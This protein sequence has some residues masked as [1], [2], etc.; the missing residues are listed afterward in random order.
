MSIFSVFLIFIVGFQFFYMNFRNFYKWIIIES[1]I[2]KLLCDIGIGINL[3]FIGLRPYEILYYLM[4]VCSVFILY[5][6]KLTKLQKK[7]LLIFLFLIFLNNLLL[8]FFPL[9]YKTV[10]LPG[11]WY[12]Y[13]INGVSS[14]PSFGKYVLIYDLY[15]VIFYINVC[16]MKNFF[17][18]QE[19]II[20]FKKI[21][22]VSFILLLSIIAIEL[23]IKIF[24]NENLYYQI[25][26]YIFGVADDTSSLLTRG[27]LITIYG[28]CTE[29]SSLALT[30]FYLGL[31]SIAIVN[32]Y[33]HLGII[34][35][36][37][38]I[39]GML[40]G[41]MLFYVL[42]LLLILSLII[43]YF[44]YVKIFVGRYKIYFSISLFILFVSAFIFIQSDLGNYYLNRLVNV[45]NIFVNGK[46]SFNS[47]SVRILSSIDMLKVFIQRPLFGAG[48]G[49]TY[50]FSSLLS[51]LS[52]FG[53]IGVCSYFYIWKVFIGKIK[54]KKS[55]YL[56]I[57]LLISFMIHGSINTFVFPQVLYLL[58]MFYTVNNG[59]NKLF[60]KELNKC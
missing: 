43:K 39:V 53:I 14:S 42:Y 46:S 21:L 18:K 8:I 51:F 36:F 60:K 12:E 25:R 1:I 47:E 31:G 59:D 29:P 33:K 15:F 2:V 28:L 24:I 40:T 50:G 3:P 37:I 4:F 16:A 57:P 34:L 5:K 32:N 26:D 27:G 30:L 44:S 17:S 9:Q 58:L 7:I 13:F 22:K 56:V 23:F 10:C 11:L 41:S 54:M 35:I 48:L 55:I 52:N 49:T 19:L 45:F 20:L 38:F 6:Y